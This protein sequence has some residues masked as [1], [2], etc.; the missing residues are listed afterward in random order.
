MGGTTES[1]CNVLGGDVSFEEASAD[2]LTLVGERGSVVV[3]VAGGAVTE[4]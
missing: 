1:G 3:E 4:F 2:G